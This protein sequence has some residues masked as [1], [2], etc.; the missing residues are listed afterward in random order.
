[1]IKYCPVTAIVSTKNRYFTTL[2]NLLISIALQ[3][4]KPQRLII[5]DDGEH[6]DL[7]KESLYQNIFSMLQQNG[8]A[9]NVEFGKGIGQ[10]AN[11]Q[12]SIEDADTEWIWRVDDDN[13]VEP[14]CLEKLFSN[15]TDGVGAVGGLVLD[16]KFN[17]QTRNPLASNN[18]EDIYYGLNIQWYQWK[19]IE[20]VDHLYSTFIFRREAA[21]QI[22][23]YCRDL[24]M[25]GHREETIFTH[26]LVRAGWKLLVDSSA[27]TWHMRD[28]Q[29]GIR[30]GS[31]QE[32]W[33]QDE[34]IFR[35]LLDE[36]GVVPNEIKLCVLDCGLGDTLIFSKILPD[37]KKKY[38][39]I[40]LAVCY[41]EVFQDDKDV[42]LISIA[43]AQQMCDITTMNIYKYLWDHT[44]D[45]WNLETAYRKMFNV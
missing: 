19:G 38:S 24:S 20:E 28:S 43:D 23:G 40:V 25:I 32:M 9:W 44:S 10:V 15:V 14:D 41:P 34:T 42:T 7:R 4:V 26:S 12:R 22:G 29:G 36:W 3:T 17:Y 6:K 8:I 2:P 35:A 31:R 45:G 11:H 37:L 27:V 16:P 13:V 1:M 5:Y 30:S 33:H 39:N 18:I 21:K